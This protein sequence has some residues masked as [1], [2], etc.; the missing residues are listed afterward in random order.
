MSFNYLYNDILN[1]ADANDD[2][3]IKLYSLRESGD[4]ANTSEVR[5]IKIMKLE[6]FRDRDSQRKKDKLLQSTDRLTQTS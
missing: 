4:G 2:K 1:E 6:N 5:E 3:G